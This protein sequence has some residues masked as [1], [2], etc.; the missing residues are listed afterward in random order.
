MNMIPKPLVLLHAIVLSLVFFSNPGWA[1]DHAYRG[2]VEGMVCAFCAYN[3]SKKIAALPG[4]DDR[5]VNVDLGSGL[6][7]FSS[8]SKV[9]KA[10]ISTLFS[11]TGFKLVTLNEIV[12][13][14]LK[15]VS[16]SSEPLV[17]LNFSLADIEQID[18]VLDAIGSLA[19][20]RNSQITLKA[21]PASE[22]DILKP[23]LAGRQK[24]IKVR[25]I[26]T[27]DNSVE[28]NIYLAKT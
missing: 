20:S 26:P 19:A 24:V 10:A 12:P 7:E 3:V 16:F 5:S 2:Q 28:L 27:E 15:P 1:D 22:I 11:D 13:S 18:A 14:D 25:F 6:V 23:I 9:D 4:V 17:T 21:L 8:A